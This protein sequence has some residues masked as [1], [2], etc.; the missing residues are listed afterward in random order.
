[1]K[2]FRYFIEAVVVY[3]LFFIFKLMPVDMASNCGGWIGRTLGPR[4]A[5]SRKA[6][7]NLRQ[8]LPGAGEDKVITQMWDN[9]GR[10]IA[11]YP[12]LETIARDRVT[13][14]N[15]ATL[16]KIK[17]D[18]GSF[19]L[20]SGHFAN[21]E[22]QGA[23]ALVQFGIQIDLMYRALNNPWTEE[24][25]YKS[26][27]MGG[28]LRAFRKSREGASQM[29]KA[30]REGGTLGILIDQKYNEG[31]AVPFFG[32]PAMTNPIFVQLGQKYKC[33]VVPSRIERTGGA[34]FKITI[35]EPMTLTDANGAN[36]PAEQVIAQAHGLMENWITEKP[37]DWLWLHRRWPN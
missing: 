17:A 8:A 7:A 22:V 34:N 33:P 37:G 20:I 2:K 5:A 26:R 4:L 9:L 6:K 23:T 13:M 24:L 27:T 31:I 19:I 3:A 25:L 11:E 10:V 15:A 21:W 32:R 30:M 28:K 14:E 18:G 1:M 16:Q 12:H 36:L 35:H 29:L